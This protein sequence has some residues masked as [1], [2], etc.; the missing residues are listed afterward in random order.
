MLPLR[1]APTQNDPPVFH[2]RRP[3]GGANFTFTLWRLRFEWRWYTDA[4]EP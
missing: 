4:N 2:T 3:Q 1:G